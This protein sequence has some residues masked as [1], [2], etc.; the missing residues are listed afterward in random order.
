MV[1]D[2]FGHPTNALDLAKDIMH[3][4]NS[5]K[6]VS[7]MYHYSN[8]GEIS[9]FDFAKKIAEM[10]GFMTKVNPIETKD[11]PTPAKRPSYSV[12]DKKKIVETYKIE[13]KDWE[14]SLR[15][16]LDKL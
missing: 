13:I 9:W 1:N 11:F 4:I 16:T 6:W 15:E 3:I 8:S 2:Q 7:G 10:K 12:L 14:K 5:E